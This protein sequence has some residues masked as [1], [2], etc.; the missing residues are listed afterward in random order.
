MKV[1]RLLFVLAIGLSGFIFVTANAEETLYFSLYIVALSMFGFVMSYREVRAKKKTNR[2]KHFPNEVVKLM[3]QRQYEQ[4]GIRDISIF[5][6]DEF[7][8]ASER[9]FD[10]EDTPEGQLFWQRIILNEDFDIIQN[11]KFAKNQANN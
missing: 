10:W 3:L 1:L 7:A 11:M 9:G 6:K 8:N 5:E 2:I 4:Q